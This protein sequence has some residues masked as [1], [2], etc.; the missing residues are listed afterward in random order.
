[1]SM[2]K[3]P[4]LLGRG[5]DWYFTAFYARVS[6][7]VF[8]MKSRIANPFLWIP[9]LLLL[10]LGF[11]L[12]GGMG[13]PE[14]Q[15][16]PPPLF[17][18]S[19]EEAAERSAPIVQTLRPHLPP[20]RPATA[21]SAEPGIHLR[22]G[23]VP[24]S[25]T[26]RPTYARPS[27]RGYPWMLLFDAP[28][29]EDWRQVLK[30]EGAVICAYLPNNALLLEAPEAALDVFGT[31]PHVAGSMEYRP[32]HKIQPLLAALSKEEPALAIPITIQTFSPDDTA[33][34]VRQLNAS[35]AS[36]IRATPAR[37]WGI[38]RAVLPARAAVELARLP[39]VQWVEHHQLPELLNDLAMA[40]NRLNI[41]AARIDH[42][43][44]GDGQIVAI[45][46]TGLDTGDTNTLHPDLAGRVLH[47]FDTG[48]LTNWSDTYYH[49][50]HVAGSLLGSGAASGG[51]Y[52]GGAPAAELVFQSVMTA[53][54]T[55]N[56]PD[57]LNELYLPPYDLEARIHSDSWGSA[58]EGEYTMDSMTTDE[59]IWD[60]PD[61][62]AVYAAGNEGIDYNR[63]GV[64]DA[65]SLDAPASAKNVLAVGASESGRASGSGGMTAR[66][67]G[68]AWSSDYRV[69][70]ISTDLISTSP[71]GEP[72]GMVAFSSRGP[73]MD[74]RIKPDLVAPGTDIVSARSR[75]STD[76]GWGVLPGN[77]NYCFMGGTSMATPLAAGAATLVRQYCV[78]SLGMAS[79]SAALLKAAMVGGARSLTPG[80]YGTNA[81]REVPELPRPNSVEG[82]GQADVTGTLFPTGG[83]EAV[84]LEGPEA[85]A[86]GESHQWIF[87]V[88]S[89]TPL[90]VVMAYSDYPSALSA[91]IN[92]VNDLDLKLLDPDGIPHWPNGLTA[93]D[94]LNNVESIDVAAAA[95]GLWTLVVSATNVPQGPQPFALYLQGDLQMPITIEHTPLENTWI[96]NQNHLVSAEVTSDGS[97]D[98]N[99]VKLIW[100]ATGSSNGFTSTPMTTTDGTHFEASMPPR[101]VGSTFWYYLSAGPDDFP[102][103]HPP[104][105][106][107]VLHS[108]E[109]LP[110]L[111]LTVSGSPS[112]F[113]LPNPVYG[114]N[115]LTSNQSLRAS[116]DFPVEGSNG[117]RT[118]CIGW[119]GTGSVTPTGEL[120]FVDITL[121][122][123]STLIWQWQEQVALM[124]TSSPYGALQSNTWHA[125]GS[126][127]DSLAAP[128]GFTFNQV[129]RTFSG[130]RIDGTRWPT[131]GAPSRLQATNIPMN[132]PRIAM[133]TY[134]PT[135]QDDDENAL[136]DWFEQ[137][138]Y[139]AL[140]QDRY[141]DDDHDGY[142]NELEA[143]DH[144]DPFDPLSVP[145]PPVIQHTPL[146]SPATSPAPWAVLA[147]VTDNYQV[148][149]ATL[150]WQRNGGLS[151]SLSMTNE[152][153]S[154][155]QFWGDIPSPA[156]NGDIIT[157]SLSAV[158]EADIVANSVTWTVGVQ[159]AQVA[160]DPESI[161]AS[162]LANTQTNAILQIENAGGSPLEVTLEIAAIGWADDMES[163]T[164]GWTH[165]DGNTVWHLS[166]QDANSPT[167]A[168]YCGDEATRTYHNSTHAALQ[169]PPIQVGASSPR[170]DFMHWA[171]FELDHDE[172]PDGI[173]YWDSAVLEISDNGG[174]TWAALVPEGGYPGLI[175]S[176]TFSPFDPDTP[177]FA[178]T[179]GWEPVGADLSAYA[180]QSIQLRFRFGADLYTVD[181]GW[182]LDDVI[183]SPRTEIEG[184][185][186]LPL[187]N[188]VVEA[189]GT[190][191]L[192]LTLDTTLLE[193]M[194]SGYLALRI[195]HND[196]EQESPLIV[197]IALHNLSRRARVTT[198]GNGTASPAGE[199]LIAPAHSFILD[200][201]ADAGSFIADIQANSAYA[202]LPE[203]ITTKSLYWTP[204]TNNLDVHVVF[205]PLLESNAVPTNWL[206]QYGL[207]NQNW[208][209]E[210]SLDPDGDALL[211]WQEYELGSNPTN[212]DDARLVVEF[213]PSA[214]PHTEWRLRWHAFTNQNATYGLLSATNLTDGFA[215]F[216]NL[217]AIP[218][219]MTSPPL[220]PNDRFFG[221]QKP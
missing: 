169:S 37:R 165:P 134:L 26:G 191:N 48:R 75:A 183:V 103:V 27:A 44:D 45:A 210:A 20:P 76:T 145:A 67:Y 139:G 180:N 133:A 204:L 28:I 138:Y 221:I 46:D 64:V 201:T 109:I 142:E 54:N 22:S 168:W 35:G 129:P 150:H 205:A 203:V 177:C 49:G 116:A 184:W 215:V 135:T 217:P 100:I 194:G 5:K 96:T 105:A 53:A 110:S 42:G 151:R 101:P 61:L 9:G 156:R 174:L 190:S 59:F 119:Q 36:D 178:D 81:F 57:D 125:T 140:G 187:T 209:S 131:G 7:S 207:T 163:G 185:L 50:T 170:L 128:E 11:W 164:N 167:H 43:L 89:P 200:L 19:Q 65:S 47:V 171:K 213:V 158:D 196:P 208:M 14:T 130:W 115:R 87:A 199:T 122:E 124:H 155:T 18:L 192:L 193:P 86:T 68:S 216:T 39:E 149:S 175:T 117:W 120:T 94:A 71:T 102:A 154:T 60:H 83:L 206:A 166:S 6:V 189:G 4:G 202:P 41:D 157:Y 137:R 40:A 159:Y 63:D 56:M 146:S 80:Q 211:T 13:D 181:E 108:F 220:A 148:A 1:M 92:L 58:V 106:P 132:A 10:G 182:R 15:R 82:W 123:D 173:H 91:S 2:G 121:T 51:Q 73:A 107:G 99:S 104:D 24:A 111:T 95:T 62:L 197:P 66:T 162:A 30:S 34:V 152:P 147:I 32:E 21:S 112:N 195:H 218:P 160:L 88:H 114:T 161:E 84:L 78:E 70:P 74:G 176:N 179:D 219:V 23:T 212:P 29:Q 127:A 16:A 33:E 52:R 144:T 126:T 90:T 198:T 214:P 77:T 38:V 72:Q 172:F 85:L 55:L 118:A 188:L 79:P 3:I 31:L 141:G 8:L 98:T 186:T 69:P 143:A 113:F 97:F 136:P 12:F 93:A 153:G 25:K 17:D